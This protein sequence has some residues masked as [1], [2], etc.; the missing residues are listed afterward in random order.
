MDINASLIRA[1]AD[2][3]S[4]ILAAL[5]VARAVTKMAQHYEDYELITESQGDTLVYEKLIGI[6]ENPT[7][8]N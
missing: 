3:K 4:H 2:N 7:L 1:V 8:R 6:F 5:K